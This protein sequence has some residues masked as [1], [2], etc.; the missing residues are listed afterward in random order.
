MPDESGWYIAVRL[1][2]PTRFKLM[3]GPYD[4]RDQADAVA[5]QC[6]DLA[7]QVDGF[8][9]FADWGTGRF[10]TREPGQLNRLLEV[11]P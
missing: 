1:P 7:Y 10:K 5:E 9:W 2:N 3:A 6:K 4:T 11:Q 8:L